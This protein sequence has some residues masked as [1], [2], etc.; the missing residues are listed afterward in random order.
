MLLSRLP[1]LRCRM[2]SLVSLSGAAAVARRL[3]AHE[4]R[5]L[6]TFHAV[7]RLRYDYLAP[8]SQKGLTIDELDQVIRWIKAR[9]DPLSA[10]QLLGSNRPG[11]LL[12]FDD[13]LANNY[14]NALPILERHGAPA[15]FFVST[16]HVL[17]PRNWLP[18]SRQKALVQW[19]R[20]ED[21][22]EMWAQH[23]F[24]GMSAQQVAVCACNPLITI[25]SHTISHP[26]LTRC[27]A[28][29]LRRELV[30]SRRQ[31]EEITGQTI[32]LLAYPSGAYDRRV[33]QAA[34]EAGYRAAFALDATGIQMP[35]YEI[36]R[37]GIYRASAH[38]LDVKLSGLYH[39]PVGP[40]T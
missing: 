2:A 15:V 27:D 32:D 5:F 26:S 3:I 40:L 7:L 35:L 30:D 21:V 33:A 36:P 20:I 39:R 24:D 34:R 14:I 17:E 13:G 22:P 9:F 11:V 8:L 29:G 19:A 4:G 16:Q 25:G 1:D 31:L 38:Y 23:L 28:S 18:H 37:V 10:E 6:L 12:T